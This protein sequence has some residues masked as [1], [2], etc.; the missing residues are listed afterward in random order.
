MRS[1]LSNLSEL[2]AFVSS[3]LFRMSTRDALTRS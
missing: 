2:E 1:V 3:S